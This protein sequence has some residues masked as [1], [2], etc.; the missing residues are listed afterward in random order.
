MRE[1]V[2]EVRRE[3]VVDVMRETVVD[4]RMENVVSAY[5]PWKTAKKSSSGSV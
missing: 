3:I 4:A 5:D 2:V 1:T